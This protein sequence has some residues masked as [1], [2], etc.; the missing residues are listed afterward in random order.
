MK[1]YF[2]GINNVKELKKAYF[3]YVKEFHT[4]NGGDKDKF[5]EMKNEYEEILKNG[6]DE[7]EDL[8]NDFKEYNQK[9]AKEF[10]KKYAEI[11]EKII[12]LENVEIEIIG[13]WIWVG[14][15][16][17]PH[18]DILKENHF[19]FSKGKKKWYW[20]GEEK[21]VNKRS[22]MSLDEIKKK[23]GCTKVKNKKIELLTC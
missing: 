18:K 20:N 16:T 6:F 1:K 23:Y 9:V 22:R 15:A 2:K 19:F 4:D 12:T 10:M 14:G 3:K 8:E 7:F 5:V 13:N 11:I 21:K 17:Y